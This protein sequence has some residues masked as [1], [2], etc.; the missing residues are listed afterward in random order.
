ML[1]VMDIADERQDLRPLIRT[2][3][4]QQRES[5]VF[6]GARVIV[7]EIVPVRDGGGDTEDILDEW[8]LS[9]ELF[10]GRVERA[11][12]QQHAEERRVSR[13]TQL[14]VDDAGGRREAVG[15]CGDAHPDVAAAE[16]EWITAGD[17]LIVVEALDT[18]VLGLGGIEAAH[19]QRT[20]EADRLKSHR[21]PEGIVGGGHRIVIGP[22]SRGRQSPEQ[23]HREQQGWYPVRRKAYRFSYEPKF[24]FNSGFFAL[25]GWANSHASISGDCNG[26]EFRRRGIGRERGAQ[27]KPGGSSMLAII[28]TAPRSVGGPARA[29]SHAAA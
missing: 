28:V 5:Q 3:P 27:R 16:Q 21:N 13:S 2:D 26:R 24:P 15:L 22:L 18:K 20:V 11:P 19:V 25:H 9:V 12:R 1:V 7:V 8:I 29:V 10:G 14:V 4:Q 17:L 23:Y 6:A